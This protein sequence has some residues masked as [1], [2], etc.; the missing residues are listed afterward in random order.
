MRALN[1]SLSAL[2]RA[3][4]A[5]PA[6][7]SSSASRRASNASGA[8]VFRSRAVPIMRNELSVKHFVLP[9]LDNEE[10][11]VSVIFNF[12][13]P[14][15]SRRGMIDGRCE[16]RLDE[17]ERHA[18]HLAEAQEIGSPA[19]NGAAGYMGTRIGTGVDPGQG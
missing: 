10:R 7:V 3:M 14:A 5:E 16:L 11:S 19:C 8:F 9:A 17:L 2:E 6:Y 13:D 12:M 1:S 4:K 15:C 18:S